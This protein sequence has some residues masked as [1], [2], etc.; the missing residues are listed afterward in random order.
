[1]FWL[2]AIVTVRMLALPP[3]ATIDPFGARSLMSVSADGDVRATATVNGYLTRTLVWRG[4]TSRPAAAPPDPVLGD[5]RRLCEN[6]PQ[7]STGPVVAGTLADGST[8]ATMESPAVVD[9]DDTSGQYAPVVLHLRSNE[10][11]NMGNGVA[12]ATAGLYTGG[13]ESY[14]GGVPAP[15]NV[16]SQNE[17]YVAMRWHD[18]TREPL[19]SGVVLAVNALGNAAGSDVPP[20][21]GAAFAAAP[22]ARIWLGGSALEPAE[23][24]PASVA[25]AIDARNRV[26]GM[27]Q[28]ADGRH[29]AFLWKDGS[30]RRIDELVRAPGW[31]FECG[32]AFT[33]AGGIVG[34]GTY[35][36]NAA[37]FEIFGL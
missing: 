5:L 13:F 30:L 37:A 23:N 11:L 32:Y 26:A 8:V 33:P 3:H 4:N 9:L 36:G 22:H 19:G 2:L 18:R 17:R 28:D 10:C 29:Y 25:Y 7:S 34:I 6:F 21:K 1:M 12:L 31:R 20:G 16:V 24:A 35:R 27:L 15:S 14:V